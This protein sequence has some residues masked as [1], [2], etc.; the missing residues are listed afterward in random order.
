MDGSLNLDRIVANLLPKSPN[1]EHNVFRNQSLSD[2]HTMRRRIGKLLKALPSPAH[3]LDMGRKETILAVARI[4]LFSGTLLTIFML[5]QAAPVLTAPAYLLMFGYLAYSIGVYL[6]LRNTG[7]ASRHFRMTTHIVDV[8][9]LGAIGAFTQGPSSPF[10]VFVT[11]ILLAAAFRWGFRETAG[12]GL[13]LIVLFLLEG[14]AF[15]STPPA[16]GELD[17]NRLI[18]RGVF[19][20][21]ITMLS[22]YLGDAQR[23]LSEEMSR[24]AGAMERARVARDLH[25]GV[26]QSLIGIEMQLEAERQRD[27]ARSVDFEHIQQQIRYEILNLRELMNQLRPL[28]LSPGEMPNYL[29]DLVD[30]FGRDTGIHAR[31]V[32]DQQDVPFSS[33]TCTELARIVQEALANVRKHSGAQNVIVRLAAL[34]DGWDLTV[35]D[36][37]RGFDFEGRLSQAQLDEQWKGP[38]V[39]K[40][41]VRLIGGELTLESGP[42]RGSTLRITIPRNGRRQHRSYSYS[43][44]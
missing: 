36:D 34:E 3:P 16:Q 22:G 25:D 39:I 15:A 18:M 33:E 21:L 30:K 1:C 17:L 11:F 29:A 6:W 43:D 2:G 44:R 20:G 13:V 28:E 7:R 37:G 38:I 41:R 40:E 35:L 19:L 14:L 23:R 8:L 31:F 26:I 12:T 24:N 42:A 9:W 5:P 27:P 10:F 32:H 4:Y